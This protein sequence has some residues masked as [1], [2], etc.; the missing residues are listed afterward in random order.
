MLKALLH[1]LNSLAGKTSLKK[2]TLPRMNFIFT[3]VLRIT[4]KWLLLFF[5]EDLART[6][7]VYL[8]TETE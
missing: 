2:R 3:L 6:S 1:G 4:D 7:E 8:L 5:A